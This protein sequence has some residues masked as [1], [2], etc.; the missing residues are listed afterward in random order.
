[1]VL[2]ATGLASLVLAMSASIQGCSS[3]STS[4]GGGG[5]AGTGTVPPAR[6]GSPTTSTD[7]HN[8]ALY[9]VDLGEGNNGADW[10]KFGYNLDGQI[11]DASYQ[12]VCNP[13]TG[14]QKSHLVDG[15]GGIDNS[16]GENIVPLIGPLVSNLSKTVSDSLN[17]GSFTI[18]LD[19]VGLDSTATQTAT[20]LSGK[21]F[22]GEHF[23]QGPNATGSAPKWDGSDVWPVNKQFLSNPADP[24]SANIV[25]NGSYVNNGVFVNGDP[26]SVTLQMTIQGVALQIPV[27]HAILTFSH[28]GSNASGGIIAGVINATQL[29]NNLKGVAGNISTSLCSGSA[30]DQIASSI[31]AA[32]DIMSDGTAGAGQTCDAISIGIGF[33]GKEIKPPSV[34]GD[35]GPAKDA[36]NSSD[37]GAGTDSGGGGQDS[38]TTQDSGTEQD[39]GAPAADAAS[40]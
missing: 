39:T 29:I 28:A 19:T 9:S 4:P 30:F 8:F 14:G 26:S 13:A 22:G 27:Q 34:T 7:E 31:R 12:G 33:T 6:T 40:E 2:G 32:S 37:A 20:G 36:C 5:T 16:F 38:G 17:K 1:M 35:P 3:S 21:I 25:F 10:K 15:P 18:M 11:T 24:K 23:D